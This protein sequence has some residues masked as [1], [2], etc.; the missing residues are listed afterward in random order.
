MI[1]N[2]Q[3]LTVVLL[4]ASLVLISGCESIN[5]LNDKF[6]SYVVHMEED[7]GTL[8]I[9]SEPQGWEANLS[10]KEP[11]YVGFAP[12]RY[13]ITVLSLNE[14]F[15]TCATGA[16]WV[17]TKIELSKN[18]DPIAQK[19][20]NFGN[21]QKG[22]LTTAFPQANDNGIVLDVSKDNGTTSFVVGNQNNN[23]GRQW[24][25]YQVTA[26][27]C[28]DGQEIMTDPGWQNGGRN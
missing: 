14:T 3:Q 10:G 19:G 13:G 16:D 23:R 28:A 11:G 7:S 8:T 26:T 18:G 25:Y 20:K 12:K 6:D 17:I 27:N 15:S 5:V 24:A 1:K 2:F 21:N 4:M 9:L 22:W